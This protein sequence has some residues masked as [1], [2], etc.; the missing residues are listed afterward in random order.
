MILEIPVL[1]G[2]GVLLVLGIVAGMAL[3]TVVRYLW[4]IFY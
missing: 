4:N 1:G 3:L 2:A